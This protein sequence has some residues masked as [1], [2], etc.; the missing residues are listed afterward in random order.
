MWVW[1][2]R[3]G[4]LKHYE[5]KI[6]SG[7]SGF[8]DGKNNPGLERTPNVGPLPVGL[9]R[10]EPPVDSFD[11][12]PFILPLTPVNDA[13]HMYGRAGFLIHGDSKT[14]PGAASHGCIILPRPVRDLIA[15]SGDKYLV[16]Q[17]GD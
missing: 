16:V 9:Y 5:E 10:I 17:S 3:Q 15:E 2:Q 14:A 13:A 4:L 12:G 7:Y 8:G 6:S 1:L 11:H